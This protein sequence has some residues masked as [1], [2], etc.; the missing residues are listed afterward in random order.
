[1]PDM[2]DLP[3]AEEITQTPEQREEL[4]RLRQE[5]EALRLRTPEDNVRY[6]LSDEA[7]KN[8]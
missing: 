8:D 3:H 4:E 1:M 6:W 5:V 2:N 7:M